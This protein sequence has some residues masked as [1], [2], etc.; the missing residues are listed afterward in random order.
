M[1]YEL[2]KFPKNVR[3]TMMENHLFDMLPKNGKRVS[4]ADIADGRKALG[5]WDVKF[6]LKN[7][8]V[9]MNNLIEKIDANRETFRLAKDGKYPGHPEVEYWLEPRSK[10][11]ANGK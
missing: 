1:S 4:S 5:K 10:K 2:T 6:P 3:Y 11:K 8:T 7:I 9:V